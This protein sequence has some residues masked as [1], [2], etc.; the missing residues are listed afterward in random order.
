MKNIHLKLLLP[1][2]LVVTAWIQEIIDQFICGG[3]C[4]LPVQ[5]GGSLWGILTAPFSHADWGHLI[6]N[7]LYFLPL[8]YLVLVNGLSHYVSV[9]VC[10]VFFNLFQ[11]LFGIVARTVCQVLFMGWWVIYWSSVLRSADLFQL[12]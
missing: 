7:T 12:H 8:S 9:W 10:V 4:N 2:F 1:V 6:G 3:A 11:L 5:P